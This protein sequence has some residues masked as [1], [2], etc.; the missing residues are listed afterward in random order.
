MT[1]MTD[2]GPCST[3]SMNTHTHNTDNMTYANSRYAIKTMYSDTL[4]CI[5]R[6]KI[7][8]E[9]NALPKTLARYV[10]L[11]NDSLY[12]ATMDQI[13]N[14]Y[15]APSVLQ[16]LATLRGVNFNDDAARLAALDAIN[17]LRVQAPYAIPDGFGDILTNY[18]FSQVIDG[19][20]IDDKA[21]WVAGFC[22][23]W[24]EIFAGLLYAL[25]NPTAIIDPPVFDPTATSP[26]V[27]AFTPKGIAVDYSSAA[28]F[29]QRVVNMFFTYLRNR[30]GLYNYVLFEAK[31]SLTW[32]DS[33]QT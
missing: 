11:S 31:Y 20:T 19:I 17:S 10:S 28:Y 14:W 4:P 27:L 16:L 30:I 25:Q 32:D 15:A 22:D 23:G 24:P 3:F 8:K 12:S 26:S 13:M 29:Y 21:F 1:S 18:R 5:H 9:K 33:F 2:G 6:K 7:I